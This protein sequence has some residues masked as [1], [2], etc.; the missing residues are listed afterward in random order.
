M[1]VFSINCSD[2]RSVVDGSP[3]LTQ[4][5]DNPAVFAAFDKLQQRMIDPCVTHPLLAS[6]LLWIAP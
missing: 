3:S 6:R 2:L 1:Q 4:R 5:N